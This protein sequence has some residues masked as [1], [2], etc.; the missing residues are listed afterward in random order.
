MTP[1]S[2]VALGALALVGGH[3]ADAAVLAVGRAGALAAVAPREAVRAGAEV[4]PD[5]DPAVRTAGPA[6]DWNWNCDGCVNWLIHALKKLASSRVSAT[7][8]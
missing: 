4:G 8:F 1:D 3:G 5:A 7:F 2:V 6:G